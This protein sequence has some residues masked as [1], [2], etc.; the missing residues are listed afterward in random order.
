MY[1]NEEGKQQP[2]YHDNCNWV[3]V[4]LLSQL[5]AST[6]QQSVVWITL[7]TAS[8]LS[9]GALIANTGVATDTFQ[10]L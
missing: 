9:P 1:G 8:S 4:R 3:V 6:I 2:Q 7:E 10:C 5:D